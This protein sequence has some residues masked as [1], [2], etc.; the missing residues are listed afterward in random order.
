MKILFEMENFMGCINSYT[1][2]FILSRNCT[3][4]KLLLNS[5][6]EIN[7]YQNHITIIKKN[8]DFFPEFLSHPYF[9]ESKKRKFKS[10]FNTD[11]F[12][13]KKQKI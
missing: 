8:L 1:P 9:F 12:E 6:V 4:F 5:L 11:Q 2:G 13:N 10:I 3:S 7:D